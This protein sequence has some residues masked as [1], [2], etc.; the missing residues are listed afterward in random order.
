MRVTV[1][2]CPAFPPAVPP[3]ADEVRVWV[4]RL[5]HPP[6]DPA[7]LLGILTPDERDR[8]ERY[9]AGAVRQQFVIGRALLRR[10]L[11]G[12]LG[13]RPHAVPITYTMAGKP[14]LA[15]SSTDPLHFNLTH[16]AGV[17]LIA[18]GRQRVGIDVE[19][20]REV[21]GMEGLV[22]RFF[23]AA[24]REAFRELPAGCRPAAFFRGW[25]CKEAVIKAA[26]ATVQCLDAFDV[27][28][29][30]ARPPAVLAVRDPAL[31]GS[32]W[33]VAHW[34]PIAGFAAAVAIETSGP[35]RV[36]LPAASSPC[37]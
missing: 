31:A 20:V 32:G 21:P 36:I 9:R 30:P 24:E 16:T 17:A 37:P 10:V 34:E 27:E 15:A 4:V 26:G 25:T 33:S 29:D 13:L 35:V 14:V 28:L 1:H 3:A 18:V 8:A 12:C 23:S 2:P 19:G 11:S 22:D 5:D 6:A 7:E